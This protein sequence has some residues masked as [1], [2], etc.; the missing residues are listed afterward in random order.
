M[1]AYMLITLV[2]SW[3]ILFLVYTVI[4]VRKEWRELGQDNGKKQ[5]LS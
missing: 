5:P 4:E 3:S 1:I 2:V